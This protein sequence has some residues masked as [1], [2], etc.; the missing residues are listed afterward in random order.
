MCIPPLILGLVNPVLSYAADNSSGT[1]TFSGAVVE[2]PCSITPESVDQTVEL[3]LISS[4]LLQGDTAPGKS[5]PQNF[6]IS[7][8]NCDPAAT[9]VNATFTGPAGLANS[10][11]S[12]AIQGDAKG[13]SVVLVDG[14]GGYVE[15]GVPTNNQI[16]Q[17]GK[18]I[19]SYSAYLEG[20]DITGVV[21]GDFNSIVTFTLAYN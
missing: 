12:F 9:G 14:S 3:G 13:A 16:L 20:D 1:V 6:K 21:P 18:N 17:A 2:S 5:T 15:S 4:S 19:L 11:K 10:G 7:L 8:E